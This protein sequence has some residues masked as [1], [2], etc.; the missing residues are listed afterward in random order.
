MAPGGD[1]LPVPPCGMNCKFLKYNVNL[2]LL[3]AFSLREGGRAMAKVDNDAAIRDRAYE[4]WEREGRPS[5]REHEHWAEA[6]Q[7]IEQE[8]VVEAFD[9]QEN[10]ELSEDQEIERLRRALWEPAEF[11]YELFGAEA[12]VLGDFMTVGPGWAGQM[13]PEAAG[14]RG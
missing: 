2:T 1:D 7:E 13:T 5:G 14:R 6:A 9:A 11:S 10:I 4:I 8:I 3:R 12:P